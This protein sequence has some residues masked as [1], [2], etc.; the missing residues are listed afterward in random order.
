MGAR[1][2][3]GRCE[4]LS[5]L[6][7]LLF[8][9]F[10]LATLRQIKQTRDL[11]RATPR[12]NEPPGTHLP[13]PQSPPEAPRPSGRSRKEKSRVFLFSFLFFLFFPRAAKPFRDPGTHGE[14]AAQGARRS[15]FRR[16][17]GA[18]RGFEPGTPVY[19]L[20]GPLALHR[21]RLP[22]LFLAP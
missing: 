3:W 5:A 8:P 10:L 18:L 16:T 13:R 9:F 21:A 14:T 1:K 15:G 7:P 11:T 6:T 20:D 12:G 22:R 19:L 2:R 17:E 4:R